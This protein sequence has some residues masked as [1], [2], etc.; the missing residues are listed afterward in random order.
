[1]HKIASAH[2]SD[3]RNKFSDLIKLES[4]LAETVAQCSDALPPNAWCSI[5]WMLAGKVT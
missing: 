4:V 2:L 1:V 5:F 3:V